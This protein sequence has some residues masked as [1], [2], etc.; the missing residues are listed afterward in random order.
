MIE[1]GNF[2]IYIEGERVEFEGASVTFSANTPSTASIAVP[3]TFSAPDIIPYSLVH[4]FYWDDQAPVEDD[5]GKII[6]RG[7]WFLLWEGVTTGE[8]FKKNPMSSTYSVNCMDLFT[9]MYKTQVSLFDLTMFDLHYSK[10]MAVLG[11]KEFAVKA[12]TF[13]EWV[14]SYFLPG[15]NLSNASQIKNKA[16][17]QRTASSEASILELAVNFIEKWST[18]IPLLEFHMDRLRFSKKFASVDDDTIR[19]FFNISKM[20]AYLKKSIRTWKSGSNILD[21]FEKILQTAYYNYVNVGPSVYDETENTFSQYI[22]KPNSYFLVPP[23]CNVI[24]PDMVTDMNTATNHMQK[25]T[26][27]FINANIRLQ[28]SGLSMTYVGPKELQDFLADHPD[29]GV[30][31]GGS[32]ATDI[33]KGAV[34]SAEKRKREE[35]TDGKNAE[36][37]SGSNAS[38]DSFKTFYTREEIEGFVNM[39]QVNLDSALATIDSEDAGERKSDGT[40]VK[41]EGYND[42]LARISQYYHDI[43]RYGD[44]TNTMVLKFSPHLVVNFPGIFLDRYHSEVG[45]IVNIT[46]SINATGSAFTTVNMNLTR[47]LKPNTEDLDA[48]PFLSSNYSNRITINDTYR[49]LLGCKAITENAVEIISKLEKEELSNFTAEIMGAIFALDG[50]KSGVYYDAEAVGKSVEYIKNYTRRKKLVTLSQVKK[51][52]GLSTDAKSLDGNDDS[53]K[54]SGSI[55]NPFDYHAADEVIGDNLTDNVRRALFSDKESDQY[56]DKE[57]KKKKI[58]EMKN[59]HKGIIDGR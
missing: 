16:L 18:G 37:L 53:W 27:T 9:Y 22:F 24:F 57:H 48:P 51:A 59:K 29:I 33:V 20:N 34:E 45:N 55:A 26:R 47:N 23:K 21:V 15:Q 36:K 3:A 35:D 46:H 42:R 38:G 40:E 12:N 25:V 28:N 41:N 43:N 30:K 8:S 31:G 10:K 7:E 32:S 56:I 54:S 2:L 19:S 52:Y 13:I 6:R 39:R 50:S 49:T 17:N 4:I 44:N 58:V 5:N 14:E 1:R 11:Q